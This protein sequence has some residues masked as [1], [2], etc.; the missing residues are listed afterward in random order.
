[1]KTAGNLFSDVPSG[2]REEFFEDIIRHRTFRLQRIVSRRHVT[3]EGQ[4]YDQE[5]DEWVAVIK[6]EAVVRF[7][8]GDAAVTL[9][10]GDHILIPAHQRHRVEWTS[11]RE[12]TVW[13]ALYFG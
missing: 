9:R 7:E 13:L 10:P 2:L 4:W 3:P 5:T 1:M 8:A 6:G 12:D 11:D